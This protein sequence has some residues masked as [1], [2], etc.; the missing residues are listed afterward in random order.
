[1]KWE[2]CDFYRIAENAV[3]TLE[4]AA[5]AIDIDFTVIRKNADCM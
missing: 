1:M 2:N 5:S 4:A 3:D